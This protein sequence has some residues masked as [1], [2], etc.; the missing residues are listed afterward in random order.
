MPAAPDIMDLDQPISRWGVDEVVGFVAAVERLRAELLDIGE[1]SAL[2]TAFQQCCGEDQRAS[3]ADLCAATQRYGEQLADVSAVL[4]LER[5]IHS[6]LAA[7]RLNQ[8]ILTMTMVSDKQVLDAIYATTRDAGL[9]TSVP[10]LAAACSNAGHDSTPT[11]RRVLWALA[12]EST[13]DTR[14][15]QWLRG[16]Y[17]AA[18]QG[19][20]LSAALNH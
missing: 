4:C 18:R 9:L 16:L 15:G 7:G 6:D 11:V 8:E 10:V 14:S 19:T 1:S 17:A 20:R 12:I 5:D 13:T 3:L 2:K